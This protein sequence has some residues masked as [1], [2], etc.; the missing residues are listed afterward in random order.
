VI[1]AT[2]IGLPVTIL[3]MALGSLLWIFYMKPELMGAAAPTEGVNQGQKAFLTFILAE[4]PSGMSGL[5]MAG[6]FAAGLGSFNSALNAMSATF[7]SD[8]YRR[9]VREKSEKH[10]LFVGRLAVVG[11]GVIM[12]GFA[13]VCVYWQKNSGQ[14]LIDFALGVMAFAYA[15]MLAVF[16][17]ALFTRRG[18]GTTAIAALITGFVAVAVMQPLVWRLIASLWTPAGE[19]PRALGLA[20]PWQLTIATGLATAVCLLGTSNNTVRLQREATESA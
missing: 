13:A 18:N 16:F 10:Y 8:V 3:F 2:A 12:G 6:L 17:C 14:N 7:V 1:V 9:K 4:M 20:F 15:G 11:W 5:M 19:V